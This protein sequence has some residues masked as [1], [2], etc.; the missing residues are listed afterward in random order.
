MGPFHASISSSKGFGLLELQRTEWVLYR[1]RR[2]FNLKTKVVEPDR[3]YVAVSNEEHSER[4]LYCR[5]AEKRKDPE[6]VT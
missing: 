3:V 6:S 4:A 2:K 1:K 5:T